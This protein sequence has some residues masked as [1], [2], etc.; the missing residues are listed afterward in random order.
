MQSERRRTLA[1]I[2][3]AAAY[4]CNRAGR[5]VVAVGA[6]RARAGDL[7]AASWDGFIVVQA[8]LFTQACSFLELFC[9]NF[10][11]NGPQHLKM[12]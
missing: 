1:T 12:L 8:Y 4:T 11:E 5:R 2:A 9:H 3:A 6:A 10:A 7:N